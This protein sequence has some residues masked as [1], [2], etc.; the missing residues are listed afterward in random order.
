MPLVSIH[1]PWKHQKASWFF[2]VAWGYR[3][4]PV[5]WNVL[6]KTFNIYLS[7]GIANSDQTAHVI[8][9]ENVFAN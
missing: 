6:N 5:V 4:R 7:T 2:D 8:D 1:T 3:K 9:F